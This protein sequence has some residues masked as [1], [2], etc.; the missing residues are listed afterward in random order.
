MHPVRIRVLFIRKR[1][2]QVVL[3]ILGYVRDGLPLEVALSKESSYQSVVEQVSTQMNLKMEN[4]HL[5][6]ALFRPSA[7]Y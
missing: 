4:R 1:L 6:V 7:L 3:K 5:T 2:V